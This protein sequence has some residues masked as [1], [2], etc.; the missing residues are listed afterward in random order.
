MEKPKYF[1]SITTWAAE[2]HH[3]KGGSNLKTIV[4]RGFDYDVHQRHAAEAL[5]TCTKRR[6][7][8]EL[9]NFEIM[10]GEITSYTNSF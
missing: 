3:P 7:A 5:D 2:G 8:G 10:A 6:D 9:S 1:L 4:F